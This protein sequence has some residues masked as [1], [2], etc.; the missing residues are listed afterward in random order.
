M[1]ELFLVIIFSILTWFISQTFKFLLKLLINKKVD[2]KI[3]VSDGGFPSTHTTFAVSGTF[4]LFYKLLPI[5]TQNIKNEFSVV[6]FCILFF[7]ILWTTTIIRDAFGIRY[8]VQKLSIIFQ[9]ILI[10]KNNSL[11]PQ[12]I[13]NHWLE[14]SKQINLNTGHTPFEV[15]GGIILG[16]ISGF[17]YVSII[18]NKFYITYILT[19]TII[20]YFYIIYIIKLKQKSTT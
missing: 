9:D 12:N 18:S 14:K 13:S 20:I 1:K 3:F 15:L 4:V 10:N 5:I 7:S 6:S 19:F 8:N 16:I 2:F 11:L 17:M